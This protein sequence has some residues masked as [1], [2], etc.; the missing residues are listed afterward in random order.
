MIGGLAGWHGVGVRPGE[1]VRIR[2][3]LPPGTHCAYLQNVTQV[4]EEHEILLPRGVKLKA[5]A[6]ALIRI[7]SVMSMRYSCLTDN[8]DKEWCANDIG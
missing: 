8:H 6:M 1:G 7:M 5:S 4:K 2:I 3:L